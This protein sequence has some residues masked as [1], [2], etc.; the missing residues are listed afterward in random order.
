M[1]S[2]WHC[3]KQAFFDDGLQQDQHV[4]DSNQKQENIVESHEYEGDQQVEFD[5]PDFFSDNIDYY[6]VQVFPSDKDNIR[7]G[8]IVFGF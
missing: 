8:L 2:E 6:N 3:M 4:V 5:I 7:V 1:R